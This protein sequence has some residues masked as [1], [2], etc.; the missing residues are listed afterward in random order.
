[1]I[2]PEELR[3]GNI[4]LY[5]SYNK[6]EIV[7]EIKPISIRTIK[8]GSHQGI[9]YFE[10]IPIT[11]EWMEK[12]GFTYNDLNGD[13]GHWQ[14]LPFEILHGEEGYSYDY[15]IDLKY[16]HQLQNLYFSLTGQELTIKEKV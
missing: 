15:K 9:E 8:G 5:K 13:S 2:K 14:L 3:I 12:L 10:A 6:P 7:E 16:I 1:M 4:I 11:K